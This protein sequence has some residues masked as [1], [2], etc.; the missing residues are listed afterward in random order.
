MIVLLDRVLGQRRYSGDGVFM[1]W[2]LWEALVFVIVGGD[3]EG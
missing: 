2:V 3:N 1:F